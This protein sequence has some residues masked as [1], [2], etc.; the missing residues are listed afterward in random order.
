MIFPEKF[1]KGETVEYTVSVS[2]YPATE[3]SMSVICAL[4]SDYP[5]RTGTGSASTFTA[6]ADGNSHEF[7]IDTS[8]LT[9][10]AYKYQ[11]KVTKDSKTHFIK[12]YSGSFVVEHSL[13][14]SL[15]GVDVRSHA[16]KMIDYIEDLLE[17][18]VKS[19]HKT[20]KHNGRELIKHSLN[21][22]R[23]LR[24]YYRGEIARAN[25]KKRGKFKS[26][27]VRINA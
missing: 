27:G 22:L 24:D 6:S 7:S 21:E 25:I 16:E 15:G 12:A 11:C 13:S 2:D 9:P 1:I 26:V 23:E 14:S 19:E 3:W 5:D 17:G 20:I 8:S 4:C 18:R 10:G